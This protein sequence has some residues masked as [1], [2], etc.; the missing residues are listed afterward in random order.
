MMILRER[1]VDTGQGDLS[2]PLKC[3]MKS[4][5]EVGLKFAIEIGVEFTYP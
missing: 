5:I 2:R 1:F 3:T 4:D